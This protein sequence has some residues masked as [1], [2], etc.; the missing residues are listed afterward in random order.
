M[1]AKDDPA[2]GETCYEMSVVYATRND[3]YPVA[4]NYAQRA[5]SIFHTKL[6]P[7]DIQLQRVVQL[8]DQLSQQ[9]PA[10]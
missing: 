1:L 3:E 2:V 9:K 8:V 4:L 7:K 5:L 6:S 10:E